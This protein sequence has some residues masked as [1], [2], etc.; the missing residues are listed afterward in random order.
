MKVALGHVEVFS[1]PMLWQVFSN[2]IDNAVRHGKTVHE[3][4]IFGA[5]S[6]DFYTIIVVDDGIGIPADEKEKIFG[7]GYGNN[8]GL[9]LF[10]VREILAITGISIRET[11]RPGRGA[12][13]E[14][15][16]PEGRYRFPSS[17]TPE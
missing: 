9:G 6:P 14:I 8:T 7:K 1:D 16:V 10:L 17:H 15:T 5:E 12:R 3:I 2:L 11:G 13:F 4:H